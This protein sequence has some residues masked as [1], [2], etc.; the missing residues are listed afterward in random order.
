[1]AAL[2]PKLG[3]YLVAA[4]L[5]SE[6]PESKSLAEN[7]EKLRREIRW[8]KRIGIANVG[9]TQTTHMKAVPVPPHW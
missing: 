5:N 9:I 2:Q 1:M 7:I 8:I 6:T 3:H 4:Q